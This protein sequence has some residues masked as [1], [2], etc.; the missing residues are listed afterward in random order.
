VNT[1]TILL[2]CGVVVVALVV[3]VRFGKLIANLLTIIGGLVVIGA[4][5]LLAQGVS[6][7]LSGSPLDT[8]A[9]VRLVEA[10]LEVMR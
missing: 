4:L 7:L 3:V 5:L 9:A 8:L 1:E 2:L 6:A 10:I